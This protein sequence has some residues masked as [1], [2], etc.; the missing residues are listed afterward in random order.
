MK[1]QNNDYNTGTQVRQFTPPAPQP[2]SLF[3]VE[4]ETDQDR[5]PPARTCGRR[6]PKLGPKLEPAGRRLLILL[7]ELDFDGLLW[8]KDKLLIISLKSAR[9]CSHKAADNS[10]KSPRFSSAFKPL[11]LLC[12]SW[13]RGVWKPICRWQISYWTLRLFTLQHFCDKRSFFNRFLTKINLKHCC[14]RT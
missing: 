14:S 5:S 7:Q 13:K 3:S 11:R 9:L 1:L 12:Y 6:E 4:S 10:L 8:I 2:S